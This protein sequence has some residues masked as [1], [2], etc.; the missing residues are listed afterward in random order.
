MQI[1]L[2]GGAGGM[3]YPYQSI[4]LRIQA[5]KASLR[6]AVGRAFAT[7]RLAQTQEAPKQH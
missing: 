5:A 6:I 1:G 4:S 2:V 7:H 3:A